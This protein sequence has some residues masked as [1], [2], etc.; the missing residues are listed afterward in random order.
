MCS[1]VDINN[2][3]NILEYRTFSP[4]LKLFFTGRN[5]V[6]LLTERIGIFFEPRIRN[7]PKH[8]FYGGIVIDQDTRTVFGYFILLFSTIAFGVAIGNEQYYLAALFVVG[9]LVLWLVYISV[10]GVTLNG[11]LGSILILFGIILSIPVFLLFA[12]EQ[13]IWGGYHIKPD[14]ATLAVVIL[15]LTIAP[16]L[17]LRYNSKRLAPVSTATIVPKQQPPAPQPTVKPT[18]AEAPA[19]PFPGWPMGTYGEDYEYYYDPEMMASY[20][21]NYEDEEEEEED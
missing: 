20:Y 3:G 6:L 2:E 13:D 17:I 19:P 16:G 4:L 12:V 11:Q 7:F 10:A 14:G 5:L 15:F 1:S 8:R 21:D 9:G 18:P